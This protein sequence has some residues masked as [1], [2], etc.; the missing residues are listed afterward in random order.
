MTAAN[1][2]LA[3]ERLIV[4]WQRRLRAARIDDRA[5]WY[6]D[7][8]A[9][10]TVLLVHGLGASWYAW[11]AN[12]EDLTR[13][14][15]VI[16]V[17][18][19][20]SG[21]SDRPPW[22][23]DLGPFAADVVELLERIDATPVTVVGHSLGGII[24]ARVGLQ[25]GSR[26]TGLMLVSAAGM[27]IRRLRLY[28]ILASLSVLRVLMHPQ[29]V[30]R[31][32]SRSPR[33][34]NAMSRG[35]VGDPSAINGEFWYLLA[36][37]YRTKGFWRTIR[38][39]LGDRTWTRLAALDVPTFVLWGQQDR[40]LPPKLGRQLTGRIRGAAYEQWAGVGHG[41]PME[42]PQAFNDVLRRFVASTT[43]R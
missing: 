22:S 30:V 29:Q 27:R 35:M 2:A 34:R 37:G 7:V 43:S 16:A 10:P 17:D 31:R 8:G 42:Q 18:L 36:S 14:H 28:A 9:G 12:L 3:P 32:I 33:L 20:G 19:P 41:P 23:R 1:P 11:A 21:I 39:I 5:L 15:R 13:D 24:A 4:E 6:L 26:C 25:L 40:L 38:A